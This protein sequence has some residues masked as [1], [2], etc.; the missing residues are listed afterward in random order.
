[1]NQSDYLKT[2]KLAKR[3]LEEYENWGEDEL[4]KTPVQKSSSET[5][6]NQSNKI[7]KGDKV[8]LNELRNRVTNCKD[9]ALGATRLT[10]VFGEGSPTAEIMFVGEG[11]GF[12]EDH[13]GRPFIGK[14]GQ[15][16]TNLIELMGYS[17][18]TVYIAN[19]VKCHPMKD[20]SNPELRGNDRP[21][22][23]LEVSQCCKYLEAQIAAINPKVIVTLGKPSA[24]YFL[25]T[26]AAMGALR[27][28]FHDYNGI[29]LMPTYHPSYLIRNGCVFGKKDQGPEI[30]KLKKE[31]WT[32]LKK[33]MNYIKTGNV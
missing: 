2:L 6:S 13:Q 1:M 12:D 9:C 5:M 27:G 17:R 3:T 11:P 33:V 22:T 14:A 19:I 10:A 18:D 16:L 4:Y 21:P 31:V 30:N 24:R 15:F 26:D 23:D 25:K 20:P 32:D 8:T 28:N 29:K 7:I